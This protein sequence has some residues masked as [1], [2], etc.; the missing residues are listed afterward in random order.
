MPVPTPS[1][2]HEA[3]SQAASLTTDETVGPL[4]Q[5][6]PAREDS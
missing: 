1:A 5:G 4:P 2:V 6:A 3:D